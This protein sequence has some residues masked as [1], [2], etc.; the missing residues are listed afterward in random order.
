MACRRR[1]ACCID[2]FGPWC[3][4]LAEDGRAEDI[5]DDNVV[6]VIDNEDDDLIDIDINDGLIN[7]A[8]E[9]KRHKDCGRGSVCRRD[10]DCD[11]LGLVDGQQRCKKYCTRRN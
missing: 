1:Q 5:I 4:R 2:E 3:C 7:A 11:V 9:C 8:V 6:V 10:P